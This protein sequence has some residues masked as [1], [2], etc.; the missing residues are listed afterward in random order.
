MANSITFGYSSI[1]GCWVSEAITKASMAYIQVERKEP[2]FLRVYTYAPGQS[3]VLAHVAQQANTAF[4]V[5]VLNEEVCLVMESESEV[6]RASACGGSTGVSLAALAGDTNSSRLEMY[7]Y[8]LG[9]PCY[10]SELE[11]GEYYGKPMMMLFTAEEFGKF[12]GITLTQEGE[13]TKISVEELISEGAA[14]E[15]N[16]D[17]MSSCAEFGIDVSG[18]EYVFVILFVA[19]GAQQLTLLYDGNEYPTEVRGSDTSTASTQHAAVGLQSIN[20]LQQL[21]ARLAARKEV[22]A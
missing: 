19:F 14:T 13:T 3:P 22:K 1:K 9:S 21:S 16:D 7:D 2:G 10:V 4:C 8:E 18:Y 15:M 20:P 11:D 5:G 12:E 17:I 6:T